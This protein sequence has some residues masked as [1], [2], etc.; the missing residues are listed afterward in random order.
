MFKT[1]FWK[2]FIVRQAARCSFQDLL[3]EG[4]F[5]VRPDW[6]SFVVASRWK[7]RT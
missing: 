3:T 6:L 2:L 4:L 7:Q 5:P 1:M